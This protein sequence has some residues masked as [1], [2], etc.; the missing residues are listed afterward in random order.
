MPRIRHAPRERFGRNHPSHVT[1]K[2]CGDVPSLRIQKCIK[3]LERTFGDASERGDFRLCH[4]SVQSNHVHMLVE[5]KNAAALGRGMKS[6]GARFARAVNRVFERRGPVLIDRY[7]MRPLK[8]PREVR[9]A[10]RYVLLNAQKHARKVLTGVDPASSARWFDG[11]KN[12]QPSQDSRPVA[13]AH[14]WLLKKGWR[15]YG[16][17]DLSSQ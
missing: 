4:Y 12:R 5:A 8:T 16:L 3:E 14:T 1:L 17:L 10:L 11:W 7:H 15:R 6:V 2:V 9:N 13:T